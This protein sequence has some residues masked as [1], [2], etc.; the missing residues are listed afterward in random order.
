MCF[1]AVKVNP[2]NLKEVPEEF[3]T[4]ELCLAAV[5]HDSLAMRFVLNNIKT[6][7]RIK[8]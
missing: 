3:L 7:I 6:K 2:F 4:T 1:E 8:K 5:E